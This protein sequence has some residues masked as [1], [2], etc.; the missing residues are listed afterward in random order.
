MIVEERGQQK[1]KKERENDNKHV[2]E[3][4]TRWSSVEG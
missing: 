3:T 2:E 4:Q 1:V